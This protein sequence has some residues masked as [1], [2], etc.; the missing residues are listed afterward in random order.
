MLPNM[1]IG[2]IIRAIIKQGILDFECKKVKTGL[3]DQ[4]AL[5]GIIIEVNAVWESIYSHGNECRLYK[6]K[7]EKKCKIFSFPLIDS[8]KHSLRFNLFTSTWQWH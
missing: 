8:L 1:G 3:R 4:K 5:I 2:Y 6:R 7:P